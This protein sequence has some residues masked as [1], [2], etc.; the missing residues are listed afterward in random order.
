MLRTQS[1]VT[2]PLS[3][4]TAYDWIDLDDLHSDPLIEGANWW[5]TTR[6]KRRFPA[7]ED[8]KP[9]QISKLLSYM[10]LLEVIDDGADFEHRIVGDVMVQAFNVPL[11]HRRFSEIVPEAPE[12]MERC[13]EIFR[14]VVRSGKPLAWRVTEDD[15]SAP[16]IF[17]QS[18]V[19]LLPLGHKKVDHLLGFYSHPA[20]AEAT[21]PA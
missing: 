5:R 12:F 13:F 2:A 6:G 16:V 15:D 20:N 14:H 11:Q 18:E 1:D 10:S 21:T 3:L 4:N 7:R 8:L 9:R 17:R 19:V